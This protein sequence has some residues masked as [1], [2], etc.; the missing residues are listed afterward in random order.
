MTSHVYVVDDD[1]QFRNSLCA[2]IESVGLRAE[3]WRDP[4]AL[5][6]RPRIDRPGCVVLDYRLPSL[7]GL[8]VLRLLRQKSS[9]P[10]ILISAYADVQTAVAAM[11][12]GA[13]TIFEKPVD[14]NA[15]LNKLER[16]CFE[17]QQRV[18][19]QAR[20]ALIQAKLARLTET[21]REVLAQ[22][23]LGY[24][25][26]VIARNLSKTIKAVERQRQNVVRKLDCTSAMEAV[27]KVHM[28]PAHEP[29]P[30]NCLGDGCLGAVR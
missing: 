26:K 16:F 13:A 1:D 17:D 5:L 28:C 18:L 27:L 23:K 14:D 11:E 2:L 6:N 9:V 3:G 30:V 7:S 8:E 4:A 15:F 25:N 24:S 10:A 22:M 20:C 19:Q 29:S 21:E 12:M